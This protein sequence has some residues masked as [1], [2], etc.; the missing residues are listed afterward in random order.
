MNLLNELIKI[1]DIHADRINSAINHVQHFF[2]LKKEVL[3]SL[4]EDDMVWIELLISRFGKLQ[5]IIGSKIIDLFLESQE[6]IINNLSMLDKIHKI[7]KLQI[8]KDAELW[9]EMRRVRNHVA[10]EYPDQ[11]ELMAKYLNRIFVLTPLLLE[12][13]D[14]LKKR[15]EGQHD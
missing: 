10:H 1:A 6:E 11:P 2:P 12:M 3:E 7:E 8:I 15:I 9:K 14:N 4:P 13:F 5:D